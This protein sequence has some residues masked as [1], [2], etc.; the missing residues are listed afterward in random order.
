LDFLNFRIS[1]SQKLA[2]GAAHDEK[3]FSLQ[4]DDQFYICN[5]FD[6][7]T[8]LNKTS[9]HQHINTSTDQHIN[10]STHPHISTIINTSTQLSTHQDINASTHQHINTSTHQHINT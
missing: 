8:K 6:E 9:T 4:L 3:Y 2:A 1:L 7:L 5:V 10:T